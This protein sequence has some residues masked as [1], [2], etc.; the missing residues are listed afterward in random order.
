VI[1]AA[2]RLAALAACVLAPASAGAG[3]PRPAVSLSASPAQVRLSG[4]ARATIRLV[5]TGS[6]SIVVDAGRAG[7]ALD[8]R[9]RPRIVPH[10]RAPRVASWLTVRPRRLALQPGRS[11]SLLVSSTIPAGAQ[12]GDHD[13]LVLLSSRPPQGVRVAVRMRIGVVVVVRVPGAIVRRLELR[14]LRVRRTGRA[15]V[16]ELFVA[17]RGNVTEL[18]RRNQ[19]T[20]SLH[21]HGR[22]LARLRPRRREL[23]P[24][25]TGIAQFRCG[26]TLRGWVTAQAEIAPARGRNGVR[27]VYRIRL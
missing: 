25:T 23:L 16:L 5:N 27:R 11:G 24:R 12:P 19:V 3:T 22:M 21:R 8:L 9:G 20:V 13:A 17:N 18:L 2:A 10:G 15:R 7:F 4:T 1:A 26:G 14:Q 6:S